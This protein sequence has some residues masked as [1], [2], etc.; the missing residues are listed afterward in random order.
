MRAVRI[1]EYGPPDVLRVEELPDPEPGPGEALIES[2]AIGVV[3]SETQSRAGAMARFGLSQ[4][5]FPYV[6][7]R[8]VAGTV[9]AVGEGVDPALVGTRVIASTNGTG[10][11]A[12]R[13]VAQ[14]TGTPT[15]AGAMWSF[16]TPIPDG[17]A[18]EQAAAL[19]GQ[20]RTALGLIREAGV[21]EGDS[22]LITAAGGGIGTLLVSLARAAGAGTI[23]AAARGGQK[24]ETARRL[25]ADVAVDY[26]DPAWG[27]RVREA[28]GGAGVDVAFDAVG[29]E[30]ARAAYDSVADGRGR[31]VVYG[32]ASGALA[33]LPM[34]EL[35]R[36]GLTAIG[37]SG[38][39]FAWRPEYPLELQAEALELAAAGKL[40]AIVGRT[41]PLAQAAAAH[42]AVEARET[43][44][45]TLLLPQEDAR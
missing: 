23:V 37:F 18:F 2:A 6:F 5:G 36:R 26:A 45:M 16:L 24:L 38:A 43:I 11:Y 39:R 27:E 7:G 44:G 10:A 15:A 29:G 13:V 8:D 35:L 25:G 1:H 30:I 31:I 41:F 21:T 40:E 34:A 33:E 42:A 3:F 9:V 32:L 4:G 19:L 17:L 28:T 14:A 20:G 12:E 22:V